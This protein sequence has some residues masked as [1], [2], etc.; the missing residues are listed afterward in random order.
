MTIYNPDKWK[1]I[2]IINHKKNEVY[3][4]IFGTWSGSY[5]YGSSWKLSSGCKS[6]E[7]DPHN[8]IW[9]SPQ[10]SGSTYQIHENAEGVCG[11]WDGF[12]QD[13]V[14]K[15]TDD[16]TIEVVENPDFSKIEIAGI[17]E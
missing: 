14:D 9:S 3:Y 16:V 4:K 12:L 1:L 10:W 5:I 17:C 8:K 15:S 11:M 13:F 7:Y 2:K 6:F